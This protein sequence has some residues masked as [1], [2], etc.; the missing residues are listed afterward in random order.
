MVSVGEKHEDFLC[1][2]LNGSTPSVPFERH[3][4]CF[5]AGVV[6]VLCSSII[7]SPHWLE[8]VFW[9][10]WLK[11]NCCLWSRNDQCWVV[12]LRLFEAKSCVHLGCVMNSALEIKEK[13]MAD[14]SVHSRKI[15]ISPDNP[16]SMIFLFFNPSPCSH[17]YTDSILRQ[18]EETGALQRMN[19]E[20]WLYNW[21]RL[22]QFFSLCSICS[23][24][25]ICSCTKSTKEEI[26]AQISV[27]STY[28]LCLRT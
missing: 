7:S 8:A 11:L 21:S 24:S 27:C 14:Y 4:C 15:F 5:L 18:N 6:M 19:S 16:S 28:L 26:T 17:T 3:L 23:P 12:P 22:I 13:Y 25:I 1:V 20:P 10:S 9:K 2:P